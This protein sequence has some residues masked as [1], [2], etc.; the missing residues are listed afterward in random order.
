MSILTKIFVVLA[1]IFAL[2][3]AAV[4]VPYVQMTTSIKEKLQDTRQELSAAKNA[5]SLLETKRGLSENQLAL[6]LE[7]KTDQLTEVRNDLKDLN[8]QI[9][10]R[11]VALM[12]LRNN[13]LGTESKNADLTSANKQAQKIMETQAAEIKERRAKM[14][15]Q[16]QEI[17]QLNTRLSELITENGMMLQQVRLVT[18]KIKELQAVNDE[19][20]GQIE[21]LQALAP[22]ETAK[23]EQLP[24][25]PPVQ[26]IRGVITNVQKIDSEI[27]AAVNVGTNDKVVE[28]ME[29]MIY[30]NSQFMGNLTITKVD[31][32]SSAGRVSLPQGEI[33]ANLEVLAGGM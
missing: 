1:T 28:G 30:R 10:N 20:A 25:P 19:M 14:I 32:Q 6:D 9:Q 21:R 15:E 23:A 2:L 16:K 11:E 17:V 13:L 26:P 29:F 4:I 12:E 7:K 33:T 18:E 22:V 24:P 27:F 31:L 5:A 3:L 8:T